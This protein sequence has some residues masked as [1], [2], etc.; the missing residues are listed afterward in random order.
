MAIN[1]ILTHLPTMLQP[2]PSRTVIRPFY[3]ED[4]AQF[5]IDG[6]PRPQRIVDRVLNLPADRA[7]MMVDMM[8]PAMASRH[9]NAEK[10]FLRRF[11]EVRGELSEGPVSR[12]QALLIGAYFS[13]EYAFESA[14][15]F[16]PSIVAHPL[17]DAA[18]PGC[19]RFVMSLR[20]IGE[21]H[22]SS[23]TFRTGTW[24]TVANQ[25]TVDPA[26]AH[27]VPPRIEEVE[28]DGRTIRLSCPESTNI[29]ESVVFPVTPSQRQG[30]EDLRM[31][32]FVEE[33]G[34][35]NLL[36]TY[37]AFSGAEVRSEMLRALDFRTYELRP[38][39]GDVV[40][41]K[42]MALF[43]RRI[44]GRYM[45]LGRQDN[46]NIW[47]LASDDLYRWDGGQK[48]VT[49]RYSWEF[50]QLGNCGSPIEIEEGWLVLTHGVGMMR[51][52]CI[53]ACLL[54]KADPSRVLG[55][56]DRPI[57]YPDPAER[58]G[59]VPNVVYSCGALVHNR[60]LLLPYGVA[61]TY[62][63]FATGS[64]DAVLAAMS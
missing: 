24:D 20:G 14:A 36:G 2:D 60:M 13:Q 21:G 37:T 18:R 53:G 43:P 51:G 55:R 30:V 32:L 8:V 6:C 26:S 47:L 29:S 64:V 61:D 33:D 34:S 17:E 56:T 48:I 28:E 57:V 50:V 54:D 16:N 9:P 5:A 11:E 4:P 15:L 41:N 49:P 63:T 52:Y 62:T 10:F 27:G 45:M 35:R 59:Y 38:L 44:D 3:A 19:L 39:E 40:R 46:E 1:T 7:R 22:I 25:V 31:V 42:G 58:G 23:V 12:E